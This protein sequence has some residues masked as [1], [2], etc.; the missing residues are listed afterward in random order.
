MPLVHALGALLRRL[1]L[2]V[3]VDDLRAAVDAL[4]GQQARREAEWLEWQDRML[5]TLRRLDGHAA[6]EKQLA[7]RD[8][9][10]GLAVAKRTALA[11]KFPPRNG[12]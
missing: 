4:E 2:R 7:A 6:R 9:D 10:D 3:Q 1:S 8:D 5:R 12:A 11:M